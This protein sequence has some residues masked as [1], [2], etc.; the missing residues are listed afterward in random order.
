META[1]Q[2]PSTRTSPSPSFGKILLILVFVA[3]VVTSSHA[4]IKHGLEA[5]QVSRCLDQSDPNSLLYFYDPETGRVLT[6]CYLPDR[7]EYGISVEEKI[8]STWE[9][10]TRYILHRVRTPEQLLQKVCGR[11]CFRIIQSGGKWVPF[12]E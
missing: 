1:L 8:S 4:I 11:G 9:N 3:I 7:G 10:V 12:G 2:F 5:D 6:F